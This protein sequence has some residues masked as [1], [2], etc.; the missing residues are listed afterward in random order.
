VAVRSGLPCTYVLDAEALV[1]ARERARERALAGDAAFA[2]AL[3]ALQRDADAAL[4][5]GPFSVT[6][7]TVM[8]P[9]GDPH[10]YVSF[11]PYWWPD[12]ARPDG[13]P[14]LRR[15]GERNPESRDSARSDAPRLAALA[16]AVDALALASWFLPDGSQYAAHAARLLR[17]WFV[18]PETRM[19]P[20]LEYGQAIPGRVSGR[21][22]GII[23]TTRFVRLVDDAGIVGVTAAWSETDQTALVRWFATYLDWLLASDHGRAERAARNNHGT[24]YDA[25]VA[26]YALFV[27][28]EDLAR[29]TIANSA[30]QR[31]AAQITTDGRQPEELARTKSFDYSVF[32]L[33]AVSALAAMGRAMDIDLWGYKS[34]EGTSI[35]AA[36]EWLSAWTEA[37]L[38]WPYPQIVP[39]ER[40]RLLPVLM[41]AHRATGDPLYRRAIWRLDPAAV[42]KDRATL[43]Y[44]YA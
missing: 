40:L 2:V 17:A 35:R 19:N 31:I 15:D 30:P 18:T 43:L 5:A 20:H 7:K 21:G 25:Q 28:R 1:R 6:H 10:D 36:I 23:D 27:G 33:E 34:A 37:D 39:L 42:A 44:A 11:G 9:S 8:A 38:P 16:D 22:I 32:N 13:L 12:P 29:R 41:Q 26:S 3:G 4:G 24:W 14:Y